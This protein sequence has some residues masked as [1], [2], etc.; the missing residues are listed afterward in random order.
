MS[1][2]V[3]REILA[4]A[5]ES[6]KSAKGRSV[7]AIELPKEP[8]QNLP[9]LIVGTVLVVLV[10]AMLLGWLLGVFSS[11]RADDAAIEGVVLL[12]STVIAQSVA[13]G[14]LLIN[15]ALEQRNYRL[16]VYE[17]RRLKAQA[18]EFAAQKWIEIQQAVEQ[19]KV[20][21]Q[22][23]LVET[24]TGALGLLA[25]ADGRSSPSSQQ[26]GA[27]TALV[28]LGAVDLAV[29]LLGQRWSDREV[30][31]GSGTAVQLVEAIVSSDRATTQNKI[32]V[33]ELLS[34]QAHAG[35][36]WQLERGPYYA[37][38]MFAYE[39]WPE[40][41]PQRARLLVLVTI[42]GMFDSLANENRSEATGLERVFLW[43]AFLA[44]DAEDDPEIRE[45]A[46]ALGRVLSPVVA[47]LNQLALSD[48][49]RDL[50]G[51]EGEWPRFASARLI[52]VKE[53]TERIRP[54]AGRGHW[55]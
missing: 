51:S 14:S 48:E 47:D 31:I 42:L 21:N 13:V 39:R 54:A 2:D 28:S 53:W 4:E 50:I 26:A 36:L 24:T 20:E 10:V 52:Q 12:G 27:I 3:V 40:E 22:R 46:I 30:G 18:E 43:L 17:Q 38:P 45:T 41:L 19:Q 37:W 8:P 44:F 55:A 7:E 1:D 49:F 5:L 35:S 25:T 23:L 29:T 34:N 32:A 15:H 9:L 11:E 16:A 33:L 6:S